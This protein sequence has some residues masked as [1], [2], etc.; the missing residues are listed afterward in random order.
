[1]VDLVGILWI[2]FL[3]P[4]CLFAYLS[5]YI[6]CRDALVSITMPLELRKEPYILPP[7]TDLGDDPE[8]LLLILHFSR[9][10]FAIPVLLFSYKWTATINAWLVTV[11][12]IGVTL[13]LYVLPNWL[14]HRKTL[15][16]FRGA[17]QLFSYVLYPIFWLMARLSPAEAKEETPTE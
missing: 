8:I 13:L 9:L 1:M 11:T 6:V 7:L 17:V 14:F 16:L 5:F 15:W 3:F 2:L 4:V 10:L 12:L